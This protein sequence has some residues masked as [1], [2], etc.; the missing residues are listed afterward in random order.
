MDPTICFSCSKDF[1]DRELRKISVYPVCDDCEIMI[2]NR[3]FPTWV[4]GFF[5]AILLIVIGSWIWNWNFYQAYGNFREALESF[6]T[7][8]VTNARR[9]MSLASDEVPEVDDLK[10]LSR[11]FHGIE[12]L[13]EDKSNEA[14]AEL[15]KC[16][17][18]LPE[19][20]NLQSLI[21]EAKIG[22]SFDNKDYHGFLD[23]AKERLAMDSTS[24]VSMTSV[25]SAY[26]C[27]YAVK[28]DEEDKNNAVRYL[29]KS[30]AIDS[31]SHEMKEYYSIVEYRLFSRNIIKR[32]DFIKQFPNGW[33]TN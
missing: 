16:Q 23:A 32:E 28:G 24:P 3:S 33:N 10:T 26:A 22:S 20:Y 7:G 15:T 19:S 4:K 9:L 31:T 13:K 1:G 8:D 29:V 5:V 11:Y 18:K 30:K 21:I 17:E 27:L 25:A 6:S 12:L 14:L 2:Q